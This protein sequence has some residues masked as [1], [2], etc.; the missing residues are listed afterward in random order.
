[1][2]PMPAIRPHVL[3]AHPRME[4]VSGGN[5][6]TVW[7]AETLLSAGFPVTLATLSEPA[8]AT[9]DAA[10]GTRLAGRSGLTVRVAP[11]GWARLLRAWPTHGAELEASLLERWIARLWAEGTYALPLCGHNEINLPIRGLQYVHFPRHW[12]G[13]PEDDY[14]WFHRIPGALAAYYGL[15]RALGVPGP[16]NW[17]SHRTLVNSGFIREFAAQADFTNVDVV[18]P[19]VV[20]SPSPI[21]WEARENR[22][23]MIGR[24]HRGKLAPNVIRIVDG[25]RERGHDLSLVLVGPWDCDAAHRREI[26]SLVATRPWLS[27]R[28]DLSRDELEAFLHRSRFGI[29][30]MVGEHFGMG[31]AEMVRSGM[32]VFAHD[33]GGP[34]EILDHDPR[35]LYRDDDDAIERIHAALAD[36]STVTD[37]HGRA[38]ARAGDF[39]IDRFRE[40]IL[41]EVDRAL[42]GAGVA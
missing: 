36:P 35:V 31:V 21:P 22:M 6:V 33:S 11:A 34:R 30:R 13:R 38:R 20:A 4:R 5:G 42:V 14:R 23:V 41:T 27:H 1:M 8:L 2:G 10:F 28:D 15:V 25:V 26:E 40:A 32:V 19:P 12:P 9:H 3:L 37:L 29:H 17:A 18:H 24:V 39:A 7:I 16:E